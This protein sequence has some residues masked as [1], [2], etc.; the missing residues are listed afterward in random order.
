M[1]SG[2]GLGNLHKH[3]MY[4]QMRNAIILQRSDCGI[5]RQ[6]IPLGKLKYAEIAS[7]GFLNRSDLS[8]P[9]PRHVL[10]GNLAKVLARLDLMIDRFNGERPASAGKPGGMPKKE[11][12]KLIP[13]HPPLPIECVPFVGSIRRRLGRAS[14]T[15]NP[16]SLRVPRQGTDHVPVYKTG[17]CIGEMRHRLVSRI[18]CQQCMAAVSF[19]AHPSAKFALYIRCNYFDEIIL[20]GG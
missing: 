14:G 12:K 15:P 16:L 19:S 6:V 18:L 7:R 1:A 11:E 4:M 13:I 5:F 8:G 20:N 17:G 3:V 9:A 2:V 10:F